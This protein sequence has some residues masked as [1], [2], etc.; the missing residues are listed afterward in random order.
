MSK[1]YFSYLIVIGCIRIESFTRVNY[2]KLLNGEIHLRRLKL[3]A[4]N[5]I[6]QYFNG[7]FSLIL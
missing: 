4:R 1:G 7:L 5:K 2:K 6:I 3:N